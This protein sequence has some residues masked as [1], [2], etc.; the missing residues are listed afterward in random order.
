[1]M[2]GPEPR[3]RILWRSSRRTNLLQKPVEEIQRVVRS[4]PGLRVV[5]D[6]GAGDLEQRQPL[7]GAVVEVDVA[8]RG[9][10]EVRLPAHRLVDVDPR[11]PVRPDHREAVVLRRDLDPSRGEVLDR[12]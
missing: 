1:M 12:V 10:A 5:L 4:W 7:D 11:A 2:I 9:R 3:I 6:G 8:E